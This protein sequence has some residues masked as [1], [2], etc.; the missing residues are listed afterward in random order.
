MNK[1][2]WGPPDDGQDYVFVPMVGWMLVDDVSTVTDW[3]YLLATQQALNAYK[4]KHR[5]EEVQDEK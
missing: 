1:T 4:R 5:E 3:P 2:P